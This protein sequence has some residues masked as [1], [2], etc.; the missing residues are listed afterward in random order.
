MLE[1]RLGALLYFVGRQ[2]ILVG[3]KKP[4]VSE[5]VFQRPGSIPVKL[6]LQVQVKT[7]RRA[8]RCLWVAKRAL[9][10]AVI[11]HHDAGVANLNLRV[12]YLAPGRIQPERLRR[13]NARR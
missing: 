1:H 13:A 5:W 11:S 9:S 7:H 12:P 8:A 2:L 10:S 3:R 6:V 4:D